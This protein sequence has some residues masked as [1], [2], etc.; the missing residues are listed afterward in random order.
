MPSNEDEFII[1]FHAIFSLV[2][3]FVLREC[4]QQ[5]HFGAS[6]I[7]DDD[8][9]NANGTCENIGNT[10]SLL[11]FTWHL[12]IFLRGLLQYPRLM[13]YYRFLLPLSLLFVFPDWFLVSFAKT[14]RFPA[15]GSFFMIGDAVSPCMAGMW[16]IPGFLILYMCYP[17]DDF[18]KGSENRLSA[19][20]YAKAAVT[21]FSIFVM[22]EQ[23]LPFIW[24][25][26]EH[27]G[28]RIGWGEGIATYVVP[29]ET[30]LG[31][32]ILYFYHVTKNLDWYQPIIGAGI[33]ML[34]YT[35]AL[36]IGLLIFEG[37]PRSMLS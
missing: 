19:F 17:S 16:S 9:N 5:T 4:L 26:T 21:G 30:I 1:R 3:A 37:S 25:A 22:A 33:S 28:H 2:A 13:S 6:S 11:V 10:V 8:N 31:P 12:V 23:L 27:V 7:D 36:S 15:N 14:L 29:A 35:G 32:I 24:T 20:C 18:M 34:I